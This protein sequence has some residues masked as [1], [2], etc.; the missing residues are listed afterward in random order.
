MV[1][2]PAPMPS[3][4]RWGLTPRRTRGKRP[5]LRNN[6]RCARAAQRERWA[7]WN[8]TCISRLTAVA[9]L[10]VLTTQAHAEVMDKEPSLSEVWL[11]ALPAA[12][13]SLIAC[14]FS[15]WWTLLTVPIFLL[16]LASFINEVTDPFVGPAILAEAGWTY[17]AGCSIAFLFVAA[18]HAAGVWWR[19]NVVRRIDRSGEN[20]QRRSA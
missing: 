3:Y 17:V 15:P 6:L 4:Q 13:V 11:V 19:R 8:V 10:L 16:Y 1:L 18:A 20:Q 12:I 14:R 7:S 5:W 9:I 2:V